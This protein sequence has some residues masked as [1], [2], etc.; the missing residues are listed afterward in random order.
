MI[1]GM[2]TWVVAAT[3]CAMPPIR[4][5]DTGEAAAAPAPKLNL[6]ATATLVRLHVT[7]SK[8]PQVKHLADS[9]NAVDFVRKLKGFGDCEVLCR[10]SREADAE[11]E[12][13]FAFKSTE[14][15]PSV[16]VSGG[17]NAAT[18]VQLGLD[19]EMH[20]TVPPRVGNVQPILL[21]WKGEWRNSERLFALWEE[22][23]AQAVNAA[24]AIPGVAYSRVEEDDDG[25]VNTSGGANLGGLFKKK[26]K[27]GKREA[28]TNAVAA[29]R[30]PSYLADTAVR[31]VPFSGLSLLRLGGIA[32]SRAP[33][34]AG[35]GKS[36]LFLLVEVRSLP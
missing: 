18:N 6:R 13:S 4:A 29:F 31:A 11:P 19:L 8:S 27:S 22:I 2:R 30:E 32:Y 14:T 12:C 1:P 10:I 24:A 25:F 28:L 5:A 33:E 17:N 7:G 15:R 23:A 16:A 35:D 9:K 3:L 20:A 21:T 34:P 36:E 26:P